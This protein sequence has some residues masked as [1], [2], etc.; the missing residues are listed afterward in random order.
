M[1]SGRA[2][3]DEPPCAP[4]KGL[5]RESRSDSARP[6]R[7]PGR[8]FASSGLAASTSRI[9]SSAQLVGG[10]HIQGSFLTGPSA[11]TMR[12]RTAAAAPLSITVTTTAAPGVAK[13][14]R[15][16]AIASIVVGKVGPVH[17]DSRCRHFLKEDPHASVIPRSLRP[18][19]LGVMYRANNLART[20]RRTLCANRVPG[21]CPTSSCRRVSR[22][23]L[24]IACR[25]ITGLCSKSPSRSPNIRECVPLYGIVNA[26]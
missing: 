24:A 9:L 11:A 15:C 8:D 1:S 12:S 26:R 6:V 2:A 10:S 22:A 14:G 23:G 13:V 18:F 25:E 5:P 20:R 16:D 17:G 4:M 7:I 3:R 19:S 21:P